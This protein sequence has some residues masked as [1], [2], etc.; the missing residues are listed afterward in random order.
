MIQSHCIVMTTFMDRDIAQRIITGLIDNKLAACVQT[1]PITSHYRWQGS[2]ERSDELLAIIK[3]K[4]SLYNRVEEFILSLHDYDC[5]EVV[6]IPISAGFGDYLAW[7][8]DEC[9]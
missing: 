6:Q 8:D 4:D 2:V 3:T 5:P 7:I 9:G 1:F